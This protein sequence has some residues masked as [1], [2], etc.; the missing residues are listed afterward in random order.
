MR[1]GQHR[2][3]RSKR[4]S[5]DLV[6]FPA[7]CAAPCRCYATDDFVNAVAGDEVEELAAADALKVEAVCAVQEDLVG[8][9]ALDG[10]P[11]RAGED[12]ET[13]LAFVGSP[14]GSRNDHAGMKIA[15]RRV[16]TEADDV[17]LFNFHRAA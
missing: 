10:D 6:N 2:A 15:I 7:D 11:F 16:D 12:V 13:Q 5:Q 14:F 9:S 3:D 4:E 17:P 8:A 1:Q